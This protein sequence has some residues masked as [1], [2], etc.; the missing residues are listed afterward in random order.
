M[1][2]N[3]FEIL[4]T[5]FGGGQSNLMHDHRERL[6]PEF[7]EQVRR[8]IDTKKWPSTGAMAVAFARHVCASVRVY[9]FGGSLNV[10]ERDHNTSMCAR[11]YQIDVDGR[12]VFVPASR[13]RGCQT[14]RKYLAPNHWWH[15]WPR[16]ASWLSEITEGRDTRDCA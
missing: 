5:C 10:S 2:R 13:E 15:A 14:L 7:V 6:A 1:D 3:S 8:Q 16:E 4:I 11:Y 9:G 12:R